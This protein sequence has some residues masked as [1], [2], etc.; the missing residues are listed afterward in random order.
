MSEKFD[1]KVF[2]AFMFLGLGIGIMFDQ[3]GAGIMIGMGLGFIAGTLIHIEPGSVV[4]KIPPVMVGATMGIL[5]LVFLLSG[6][7]LLIGLEIPWK[8]VGGLALSV[9]GVAILVSGFKVV[10][11]KE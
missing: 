6:L 10:F 8:I 9:V 5:G 1:G 2:V 11:K 4:L 3:A 7:S